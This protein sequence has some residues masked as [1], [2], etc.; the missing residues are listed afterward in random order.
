MQGRGKPKISAQYKPGEQPPLSLD[1]KPTFTESIK[2]S[3]KLIFELSGILFIFFCVILPIIIYAVHAIF[4]PT[5]HK[6]ETSEQWAASYANNHQNFARIIGA[7]TLDSKD[8][9]VVLANGSYNLT[10]QSVKMNAPTPPKTLDNFYMNTKTGVFWG[11]LEKAK[12]IYIEG[13]VKL[14]IGEINYSDIMKAKLFTNK[15]S[16]SDIKI[17]YQENGHGSGGV[18]ENKSVFIIG[19][20]SEVELPGGA[21]SSSMF[22]DIFDRIPYLLNPEELM[23]H[24]E[25]MRQDLESRRT[26]KNFERLPDERLKTEHRLKH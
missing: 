20:I 21:G 12:K 17:D 25:L 22:Y 13:D 6:T 7:K 8:I 9:F 1:Y 3:I 2:D 4:D 11:S 15:D 5:P 10:V 16:I 24:D 23:H 26:H 14:G 18:S 19:S